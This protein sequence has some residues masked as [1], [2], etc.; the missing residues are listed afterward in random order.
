MIIDLLRNDLNS[1]NL[2][3]C[4]VVRKKALL[5]VPGLLHQMGVI[6][7]KLP[8]VIALGKLVRC[9]FPGGSI[10]GAPKKR[11]VQIL[12][13]IEAGPRGIYTGS[14]MLLRNGQIDCSINIRTAKIN[15][16]ESS[17]SYGS[18]GGITLQSNCDAEFQEMQIKVESF[19]NTFFKS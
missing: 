4:Q 10:T 13:A 11:T 14:T 9:L 15:L 6:K 7:V 16:K 18:G 12:R 2:P 19:L 1:I 3:I 17:L 8:P 5:V